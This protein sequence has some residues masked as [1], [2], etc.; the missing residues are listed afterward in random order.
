MCGVLAATTACA[1]SIDNHLPPS[2]EQR[3]KSAT[4]LELLAL[5]PVP[6]QMQPES[7]REV[8][9]G[10]AVLGRAQLDD[11]AKCE[12]LVRL[13]L[14]GIR[15][16]DGTAAWCFDPRHGLRLQSDSGELDILICYECMQIVAYE[17]VPDAGFTQST[18][19]TSSKVE[20]AVTKLFNEAGLTIAGR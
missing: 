17:S 15:D 10:H 5:D 20:P 14:K 12:Q 18:T 6:S 8:F 19:L 3:L 11:L 1:A 9:H 2:V 13:V 7:D 4:S 16:S